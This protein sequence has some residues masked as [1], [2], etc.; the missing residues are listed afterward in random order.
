M[1][2][3]GLMSYLDLAID[4]GGLWQEFIA[5]DDLTE[6]F[7]EP[8]RKLIHCPGIVIHREDGYMEWIR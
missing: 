7:T 6:F 3:A 8:Y 1:G 2:R 5:V 4:A